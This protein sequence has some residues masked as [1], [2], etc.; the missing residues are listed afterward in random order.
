MA[1]TIEDK[2]VHLAVCPWIIHRMLFS[3][4]YQLMRC[5]L[6]LIVVLVRRDLSKDAALPSGSYPVG[7][8]LVIYVMRPGR[9]RVSVRRADRAVGGDAGVV[10]QA[11]GGA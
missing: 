6:G 9:I 7:A 4:L 2:G 3:I 8:E 5:L 10:T 1:I 11:V